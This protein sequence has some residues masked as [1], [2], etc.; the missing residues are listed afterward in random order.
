MNMH[1]VF[2]NLMRHIIDL[3]EIFTEQ[4]SAYQARAKTYSNDKNK[5][6]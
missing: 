6:V 3:L 5:I 2:K 4:S 1:Q